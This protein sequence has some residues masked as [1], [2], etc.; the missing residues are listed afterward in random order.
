[1]TDAMSTSGYTNYTLFRRGTTVVGYAECVPAVKNAAELM[2]TQEV[3]KLWNESFEGVI[4]TMTDADG[5][6]FKVD[7]VWHLA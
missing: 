4:E 6:L 1:M 7:E 2:G 5:N 3:A